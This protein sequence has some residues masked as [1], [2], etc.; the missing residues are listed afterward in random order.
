[1]R[2]LL[3]LLIGASGLAASVPANAAL[4]VLDFNPAIA[5]APAECTFPTQDLSP[6]YGSTAQLAISYLNRFAGEAFPNTL[7]YINFGG[8]GSGVAS[9]N[10]GFRPVDFIFSPI[11]GYEVSL[12]SV[13]NFQIFDGAL[14]GTYSLFDSS[15]A[16]ISSVGHSTPGATDPLQQTN[17]VTTVFNSA[18][19]SNPL[20]LGDFVESGMH[21]DNL[22]LDVRQISSVAAVPEPATWAMMIL[23][24][25]LIGGAMRRRAGLGASAMA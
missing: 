24:F 21:Y 18:Y 19:F 17:R 11:A 1:M 2:K 20:R 8:I 3:T 10:P 12:I 5:C 25:G 13:D 22:T 6:T 14:T 15:D 23:G 4:V 9:G 16:L 7:N